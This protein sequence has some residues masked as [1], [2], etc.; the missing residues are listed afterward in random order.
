MGD[1][2]GL[3]VGLKGSA[4]I[5]VGEQHTAPKVGS[6]RVHVWVKHTP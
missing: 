6:G 5:V 3:R 4:E 2:A 1:I